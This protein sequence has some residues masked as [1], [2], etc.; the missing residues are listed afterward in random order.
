[1]GVVIKSDSAKFDV[2]LVLKVIGINIF[3]SQ[4][5]IKYIK[6]TANID[7]RHFINMFI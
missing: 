2:K 6:D 5:P 3:L 1:M 7:F 4:K